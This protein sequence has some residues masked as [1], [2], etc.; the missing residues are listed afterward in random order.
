M[1]KTQSAQHSVGKMLCN[2]KKKVNLMD[3]SQKSTLWNFP[4]S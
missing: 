1:Q 4:L 2:D 3:E